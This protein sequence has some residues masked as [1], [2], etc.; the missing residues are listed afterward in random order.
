MMRSFAVMSDRFKVLEVASLHRSQ[1]ISSG[2]NIDVGRE[3]QALTANV[4]TT[5]A[6]LVYKNRKHRCGC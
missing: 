6:N 1:N 5:H 4:C 2:T 3:V